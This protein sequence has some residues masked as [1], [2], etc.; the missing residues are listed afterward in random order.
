MKL[1][2]D[3]NDKLNLLIQSIYLII[4]IIIFKYL[5]NIKWTASASI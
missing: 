1:F 2:S 5:F 3:I 4:S